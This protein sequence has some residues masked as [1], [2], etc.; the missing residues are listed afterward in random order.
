MAIMCQGED[1]TTK[2]CNSRVALELG[3]SNSDRNLI[4]INPPH[5]S[6][7]AMLLALQAR[8]LGARLRPTATRG[9]SAC[10]L[11]VLR[12]ALQASLVL[13]NHLTVAPPPGLTRLLAIDHSVCRFLLCGSS[14]GLLSV[15]NLDQE[16]AS[17]PTTLA[18]AL[19]VTH[20]A[21]GAAVTAL[22]W[23][24]PD[25][26]LFVSGGAD[27][28]LQAWDAERRACATRLQVRGAVT[29]AG[30]LADSPVVAVAFTPPR[31][32][33]APLVRLWDLRLG[34][35]VHS[36][37]LPAAPSALLVPPRSSLL[38]VGTAAGHLILLDPRR[39]APAR[40]FSGSPAGAGAS[41]VEVAHHGAV[42]ALAAAD[43]ERSLLSLGEDRR[44]RLWSSASGADQLVAYPGLAPDPRPVQLAVS[45]AR[46]AEAGPPAV[47]VPSG[48]ALA[49]F[50]VA[51]APR[52]G[53]CT[54]TWAPCGRR[55]RTP[56]CRCWPR[57]ATTRTCCCGTPPPPTATTSP[58]TPSDSRAALLGR[59]RAA[60]QQAALGRGGR[61]GR[62]GLRREFLQ[63]SPLRV[64]AD[65]PLR[66][67][68]R[69]HQERREE[70][71]IG[72]A[73]HGEQRGER[74]RRHHAAQ[75]RAGREEHRQR[76]GPHAHREELAGGEVGRRAPPGTPRRRRRTRGPSARRRRA[77]RPRTAPP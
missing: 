38:G 37:S 53:G 52:S 54:A 30:F 64:H 39:P 75:E 48:P 36:F 65:Q 28:A 9:L 1:W 15:Y 22:G 72:Q 7:P 19:C 10:P 12:H 71:A 5:A 47:Y 2:R 70:I 69:P 58:R 67:G 16:H 11:A 18:P 77:C 68:G 73:V 44:L 14:E 43:G 42:T 8:E 45:G 26:G 63:T 25:P 74:H 56:R 34:A 55:R 51:R 27:G 6:P 50:D 46:A 66:G 31:P 57:P 40:V 3:P 32:A 76:E 17:A 60:L 49:A 13:S 62:G 41:G 21:G 29:G 35:A 61:G 23:Y 24:G 4:V 33:D 59:R 20:G